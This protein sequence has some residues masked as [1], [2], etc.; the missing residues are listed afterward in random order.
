M[1]SRSQPIIKSEQREQYFSESIKSAPEIDPSNVS[2]L[3]L[4]S[5][6]SIQYYIDKRN[7]ML[8]VEMNL[9]GPRVEQSISKYVNSPYHGQS[10]TGMDICLRK[11][12][13]VTCSEKVINVWNYQD[14]KLQIAASCS[15]TDKARAVAFHPNG[16]HI[17]AA[18]GEKISMMNVLSNAIAEQTSFVLK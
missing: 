1:L 6:E 8:K 17:V 16:F 18:V 15:T 12:L 3:A 4:D 10:I 13:I 2:S 5:N 11:P 14:F 9:S 7:Q